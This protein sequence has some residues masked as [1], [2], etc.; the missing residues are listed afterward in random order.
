MFLN[1]LLRID[2]MRSRMKQRAKTSTMT[3][4]DQ[5]GLGAIEVIVPS[6]EMQ[7][8]FSGL[9]FEV[10]RSSASM[11]RQGHHLRDLFQSIQQRAFAEKA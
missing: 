1:F 10:D 7:R 4:I 3:T 9:L 2:S 11:L 5:K 8:R 6:I